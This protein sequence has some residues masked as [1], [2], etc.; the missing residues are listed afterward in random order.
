MLIAAAMAFSLCFVGVAR[1]EGNMY[2]VGADA[3]VSADAS[4]THD[5]KPWPPRPLPPIRPILKGIASST[6]E[7]V[8][9]MK[10]K[11]E[12]RME[13]QGGA[14]G[15]MMKDKAMELREKGR[16]LAIARIKLNIKRFILILDAAIKREG[17]LVE[18]VT[19]RANKLAGQGVDITQVQADLATATAEIEAAKTDLGNIGAAADATVTVNASTTPAT[20]FGPIRD[21]LQS[22]EKHI[23][24][25]HQA[26]LKALKDLRAAVDA[27]GGVDPDATSTTP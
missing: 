3:S 18:R 4:T 16:E 5:G 26:I 12:A 22:A 19:S 7:H 27:H 20:V 10:D 15:T 24:A 25:A 21:L 1:A 6:K 23:R 17:K 8:D 13:G 11:M 9:A 14:T 2:G